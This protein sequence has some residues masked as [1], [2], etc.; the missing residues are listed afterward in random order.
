MP[1]KK[2]KIRLGEIKEILMQAKK[3]GIETT[4]FYIFGLDDLSSMKRGFNFL[5]QAITIAPTGPNY[6]HQGIKKFIK[7]KPLRYFLKA[8]TI[9]KEVHGGL[10]RFESCQNFRSLWPLEQTKVRSLV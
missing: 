8:K 2:G 1:G 9:Y 6:Q 5:K 3:M 7:I 10:E 4:Y